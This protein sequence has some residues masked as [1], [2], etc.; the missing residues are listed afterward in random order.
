M[1]SAEI[2]FRPFDFLSDLDCS[3]QAKWENDPSIRHLFCYFPDKEASVHV[4]T[5]EEV[6]LRGLNKS[7]KIQQRLM[8]LLDSRPVGEMSVSIDGKESISGL[9]GTA[10]IGIVLGE[11]EARGRG[12]GQQAMKHLESQA[13]GLGAQRIE[14]GVFSF[15]AAA[16]NFY[17]KLNYTEFTR[18]PDYA[19]WNH[20]MWDDIRMVKEVGPGRSSV[21]S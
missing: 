18:I 21:S 9:P 15:N 4:V 5:A 13:I 17:E 16:I 20:R 8:I 19:Y 2:T 6:G 3:L 14:L 1:S 12:V 7:K 11:P 10:W